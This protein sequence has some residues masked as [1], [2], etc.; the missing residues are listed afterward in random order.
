MPVYVRKFWIEKSKQQQEQHHGGP[1]M[2]HGGQ[3]QISGNMINS[4]AK[5]EQMK[6]KDTKSVD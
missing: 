4:F 1:N 5:T 6:L 3:R 2:S